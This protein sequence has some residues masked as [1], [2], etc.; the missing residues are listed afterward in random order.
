MTS[1][2]DRW[3]GIEEAI[4]L[5]GERLGLPPSW[6]LEILK[7][8]P[9]LEPGTMWLSDQPI[10]L[11]RLPTGFVFDRSEFEAVLA[12]IKPAGNRGDA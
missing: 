1:E 3:I 11:H 2:Q 10:E 7:K 6:H 9:S 12:N 4:R 8:L 5:H